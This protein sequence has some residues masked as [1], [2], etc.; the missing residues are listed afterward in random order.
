MRERSNPRETK[1]I[2]KERDRNRWTDGWEMDG[3]AVGLMLTLS[4]TGPQWDF[5]LRS[6]SYINSTTPTYDFTQ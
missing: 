2:H 3:Q 6:M 4:P 5:F 1:Q